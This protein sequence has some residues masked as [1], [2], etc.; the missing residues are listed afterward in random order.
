ML[1][2]DYEAPRAKQA[3]TLLLRVIV[4]PDEFYTRFYGS[5]LA[6]NS[7]RKQTEMIKQ[8][9]ANTKNSIYTLYETRYTIH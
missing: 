3:Q 2:I 7:A 8:A 4:E 6:N 9:L 1:E 5:L